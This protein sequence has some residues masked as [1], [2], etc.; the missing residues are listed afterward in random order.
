MTMNDERTWLDRIT[1]W[2]HREPTSSQELIELLRD[3]KDMGVIDSDALAMIEGILQ[4]AEMRVEDIMVPRSQMV[5]IAAEEK[6]V[7]FLPKVRAS[8]HSR[9]PVLDEDNEKVLGILLAKD[10]LQFIEGDISDFRWAEFLRPAHLVP[11]SKRLDKLLQEFRATHQHIALVVDE[12]GVVTGLVTIEDILEQIV[13]EIEDEYDVDDEMY[14]K[15]QDDGQYIVKAQ[16]PLQEFNEYFHTNFPDTEAS[17]IAGY[18]LQQLQRL[19]QR[20]EIVHL[21]NCEFSVLHA[22][23]RRIRLLAVKILGEEE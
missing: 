20:G 4:V 16:M 11:D 5:F 10:L 8:E 2:F 22:D 17:T 18:L 6:P 12:Y 14:V 7:D 13:G 9:F 3:V 19:P 1:H 23:H 21:A 15:H